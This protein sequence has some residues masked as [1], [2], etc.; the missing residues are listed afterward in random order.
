MESSVIDLRSGTLVNITFA[1]GSRADTPEIR[2]VSIVASPG[3]AFIFSGRVQ[4]L[5]LRRGMLV[6]VDPP[7]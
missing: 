6:I 3:Q 4:F 5:D 7:T 1:A 2:E